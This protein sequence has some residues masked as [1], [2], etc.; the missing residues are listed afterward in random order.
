MKQF[1]KTLG[2]IIGTIIVVGFLLIGIGVIAFFTVSIVNVASHDVATHKGDT[3][4]VKSHEFDI[5]AL[6]DNHVYILSRYSSDEKIKYHFMRKQNG[7]YTNGQLPA[8]RTTIYETDKDDYRVE[9]YYE[10]PSWWSDG[11]LETS[12]EYF[13]LHT[14]SKQYKVYVPNDSVKNDYNIDLN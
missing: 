9:V 3:R 2:T 1:F 10:I 12:K 4:L 8:S 7:G 5:Y 11:W 6:Q 13:G 14:D